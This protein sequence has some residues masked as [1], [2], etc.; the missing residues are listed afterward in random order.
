MSKIRAISFLSALLLASGTGLCLDVDNV[1]NSKDVTFSATSSKD[2]SLWVGTASRGLLRLG[3]TGRTYLYSTLTGDIPCDSIKALAFASDGRLWMLD[4]HGDSFSYSSMTGFV[5]DA[6]I[7]SE[8][9]PV[10]F[11]E[12][13][14]TP[15]VEVP[16]PSPVVASRPWYSRWWTFFVILLFALAPF[17][18]FYFL[19]PKPASV[20]KNEVPEPQVR[21]EIET[22]VTALPA[23]EPAVRPAPVPEGA[24]GA[25]YEQVEKIVSEHYSDPSF[26][27]EEVASILGITRV[28]LSRKLKAASCPSP[29]EMI[30]SARMNRAAELIK[31]GNI[32]MSEV[33]SLSGFSSSAYFS[34][35][36]KEYF[37]VSPSSYISSE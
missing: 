17:V 12:V 25:F 26:G 10:F 22:A 30:K 4:A 14:E 8:V 3:V 31:S 29:S 20:G 32:N 33:A 21:D 2:G 15:A 36:F 35:A 18:V 37:G 6:D 7:P 27:V 5:K 1:T 19:R 28:H 23:V 9:S 24:G 11:P 13:K 34:S 16:E